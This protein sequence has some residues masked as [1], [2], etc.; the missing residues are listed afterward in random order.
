MERYN[1]KVGDLVERIPDGVQGIVI[2]VLY[3][4]T[5]YASYYVHWIHYYSFVPYKD[6]EIRKVKT[7][8]F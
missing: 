8:I 6:T 5:V 3:P 2:N 7:D 1:I 4:Q